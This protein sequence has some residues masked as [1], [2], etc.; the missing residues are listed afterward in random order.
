MVVGHLN[1]VWVGH[2]DGMTGV[3]VGHMMEV[4]GAMVGHLTGVV[5][6]MTGVVEKMAGNLTVLGGWV[7]EH[8]TGMT[9]KQFP[10]V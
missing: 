1:V 5:E 8:L 6:M 4:T 9:C 3:K 7:G 2:L 10:L